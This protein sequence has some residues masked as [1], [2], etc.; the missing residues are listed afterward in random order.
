MGLTPVRFIMLE[1]KRSGKEGAKKIPTW[2]KAV[3]R[4]RGGC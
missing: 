1:L 4:E 2:R 3:N